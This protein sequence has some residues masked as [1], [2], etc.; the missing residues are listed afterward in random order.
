MMI[1]IGMEPLLTMEMTAVATMITT[2]AAVVVMRMLI[3]RS[4]PDMDTLNHGSLLVGPPN[5]PHRR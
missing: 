5:R 2:T 4:G 3:E 1:A